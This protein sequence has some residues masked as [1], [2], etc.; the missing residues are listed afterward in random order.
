MSTIPPDEATH[1]ASYLA[2]LLSC[3]QCASPLEKPSRGRNPRYCNEKCKRRYKYKNTPRV[4]DQRSREEISAAARDAAAARW[5]DKTPE[6][7]AEAGRI[8]AA[9]RYK[10]HDYSLRKTPRSVPKSE[11]AC[12]FCGRVTL[13][14]RT[15]QS[16][17]ASKCKLAR[18]AERN[19]KYAAARRAIIRGL[20]ADVFEPTEIF[21]RDGWICQICGDDVDR[22]A[23]WPDPRSASLDHIIP[24]SRGGTHIRENAQCSHFQ[25]NVRKGGRFSAPGGRSVPGGH[26][27]VD[28]ACPEGAC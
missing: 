1:G 13:M 24:L 15:Q 6:Q 14:A 18:N 10:D 21:D 12:R 20:H 9:A 19:R 25:C 22:S 5:A 8:A 17:G 27:D 11:R 28:R 4:P 7:R 16:C 2:T 23:S 3:W 26:D